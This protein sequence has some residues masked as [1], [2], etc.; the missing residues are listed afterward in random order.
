MLLWLYSKFWWLNLI[1][2]Y[3]ILLN[4]VPNRSL[5]QK[6]KRPTS[7]RTDLDEDALEERMEGA[8]AAEASVMKQPNMLDV[9]S[10]FCVGLGVEK[11]L[12]ICL[13][14]FKDK[15]RQTGVSGFPL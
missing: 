8:E 1:T 6:Q 4:K 5:P 14:G 12:P 3:Y 7:T 11:D 2:S 13:G 9:L 10:C 15:K